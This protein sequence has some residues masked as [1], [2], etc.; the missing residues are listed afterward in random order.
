MKIMFVPCTDYVEL[1]DHQ[2]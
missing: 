1:W 2:L